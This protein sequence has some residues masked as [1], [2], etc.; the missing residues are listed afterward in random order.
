MSK[1]LSE[2]TPTEQAPA[3]AAPGYA[4]IAE[5][6]AEARRRFGDDP[7]N[8]R[9]VCPSCGH[10]AS[11]GDWKAVGAS[12]GEVAFSC[13]GR[14]IASSKRMCEKPGPCN[15]A[16]GGLI[17]LNPVVITTAPGKTTRVFAFA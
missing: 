12:E 15:Y 8:W 13:V 11:V 10:V 5:W 7:M 6:Q 2:S 9:F 4:S 3:I 1:N 17:G 16:G 14:H